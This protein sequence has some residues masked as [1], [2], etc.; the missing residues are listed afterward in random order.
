MDYLKIINFNN[1]SKAGFE[2]NY[3]DNYN[4]LCKKNINFV[5]ILKLLSDNI[6]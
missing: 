1:L 6:I 2:S 5:K 3:F 4:L